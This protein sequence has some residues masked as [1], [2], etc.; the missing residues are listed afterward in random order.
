MTLDFDELEIT[1]REVYDAMQYG[2]S[3]PDRQS[4]DEINSLLADIRQLL[5]PR[6]T[7]IIR[8]GTLAD[9]ILQLQD[10]TTFNVGRIIA[11]QLKA[12][13]SFAFFICTAGR[14]FMDYQERIKTEGDIFKIFAVDSI[15]SVIAEKCA[16]VMEEYL[17]SELSLSNLHRTNRFSPGYCGWH[18]SEQQKLFP[19]FGSETVG[20]ELTPS[21]LM[22]PIKSVSGV[23]G[24]GSNVSK[25]EYACKLCTMAQCFRRKIRIKS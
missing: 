17:Q 21:S 22:V 5:R 8:K 1:F 9:G 6:F 19:L 16:D 11:H 18:V 25:K 13:E 23:I 2:D 12:S 7:Y 20:V 4:A 14:E 24:V 10:G 15:G 3:V